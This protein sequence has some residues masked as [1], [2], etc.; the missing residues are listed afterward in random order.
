M[1]AHNAARFIEAAIESVCVQSVSDWELLISDDGSSDDTV[2][3]AR[4]TLL[5]LGKSSKGR[6]LSGTVRQG[7]ARARNRAIA[8]ARGKWLAF[9]DSDD[10]WA[11]D[12]L[13]RQLPVF[14]DPDVR[15]LCGGYEVIDVFGRAT[16]EYCVPPRTASYS[17]MLRIN[18]VGCLTAIYDVERAG[19][20]FMPDLPR[21]QDYGLWLSLIRPGGV[22]YGLQR[23]VGMYRRRSTGSVSSNKIA[24]T[25]WQWRLYRE[26]EKLSMA[27]SF[28]CLFNH[29]FRKSKKYAGGGSFPSE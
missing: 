10:L 27:S 14:D 21:R 28:R 1:P 11:K 25:Y 16:G 12:K 18:T 29:A 3:V 24:A 19:K 2:K 13:E 23:I 7:P 4:D 6:I 22:V 26:Y 5:R 17:D 20:V 9:L 15:L 8:E